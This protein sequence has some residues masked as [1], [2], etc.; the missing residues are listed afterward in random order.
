ML[1]TI[2]SDVAPSLET[3]LQLDLCAEEAIVH[4]ITFAHALLYNSGSTRAD[5]TRGLESRDERLSSLC[6]IHCLP[7]PVVF[8]GYVC[9]GRTYEVRFES[10]EVYR[11]E[12]TLYRPWTQT[13]PTCL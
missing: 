3:S 8:S 13:I 4:A 1:A 10:P 2:H 7:I 6:S 11:Q 5:R 12:I 9:T